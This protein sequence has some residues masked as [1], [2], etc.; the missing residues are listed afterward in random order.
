M[1]W[2]GLSDVDPELELNGQIGDSLPR[3]GY[4]ALVVDV[5]VIL[6]AMRSHQM[7]CFRMLHYLPWA[8]SEPCWE[9]ALGSVGSSQCRNGYEVAD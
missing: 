5:G 3:S 2:V 9:M 4:L 6:A 7:R 8:C 1:G